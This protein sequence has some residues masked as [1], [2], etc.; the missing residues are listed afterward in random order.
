[1][2]RKCFRAIG[3][4][5]LDASTSRVTVNPRAEEILRIPA[6]E[7]IG[8][9]FAS[10]YKES[11]KDIEPLVDAL[12]RGDEHATAAAILRRQIGKHETILEVNT[13]S[14]GGIDRRE[15]GLDLLADVTERELAWRQLRRANQ[16]LEQRV[17]QR[18]KVLVAQ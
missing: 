2:G 16:E 14:I 12:R 1:M 11:A 4:L 7:L 8:R 5:A 10:L 17:A 18:T 3:F 9:D 6:S 15:H 13:A